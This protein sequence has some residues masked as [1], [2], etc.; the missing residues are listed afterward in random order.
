MLKS[1]TFWCAA[2]LL[3]LIPLL[4]IDIV[5]HFLLFKSEVYGEFIMVAQEDLGLTTEQKAQILDRALARNTEL[6][7]L[8]YTKGFLCL[9]LAIA[10]ALLFRKYARQSPTPWFKTT[11]GTIMVIMLAVIIKVSIVVFSEGSGKIHFI[12]SVLHPKSLKDVLLAAN[13]NSKAV[14]VDFWGTT[15]GPCLMEFRNFTKPVKDRFNNPGDISYL[16]IAQGQEYLWRKLIDKYQ[17]EGYHIFLDKQNYNS[18][19]RNAVANDTA[20]I[21]MPRY[22]ITNEKGE[23]IVTD[24]KRPSAKDALFAELESVIKGE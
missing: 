17:V 13:L 21:I 14:Y 4:I 22:V 20:L 5:E 9:I 7:F 10:S 2:I 8:M 15:C 1:I 24:A 23:V 19:F 11:L 12:T 3:A 6:H 16:Y 18:L